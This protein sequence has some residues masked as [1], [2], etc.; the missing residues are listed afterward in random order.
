M[1]QCSTCSN[2]IGLQ[3][4]LVL[5]NSNAHSHSKNAGAKISRLEAELTRVENLIVQLSQQR[6]RLKKEI[7]ALSLTAQL[8]TEILLEIFRAVTHP[9]SINDIHQLGLCG[10]SP[11]LLGKV[12]S[13]W[14]DVAWTAPLLWA[15]IYIY[16]S[17][18]RYTVQTQLLGEWLDRADNLPLNIRLSVKAEDELDWVSDPPREVMSQLA[19]YSATWRSVDLFLPGSCYQHI[20]AIKDD[21]PLLA[22][23][24][25]HT[26]VS[27]SGKRLGMFYSAPRLRSVSL[28][29]YFLSD[30]HLPWAQF[31]HLHA[32]TFFLDE[33]IEALRRA[34]DLV[35]C[36]FRSIIS[37]FSC[38]RFQFPT[39]PIV[40][41]NLIN[42]QLFSS[43]ST[44]IHD[45]LESVTLTSLLQLELDISYGQLFSSDEHVF[46]LFLLRSSPPLQRLSIAGSPILENALLRCLHAIPSLEEL[47]LT[48]PCDNPVFGL[49][50]TFI[51]ALEIN[52]S[53]G[54]FL[55]IVP[56][57]QSFTYEGPASFHA[58]LLL[59][60]LEKRC[61]KGTEGL[62]HDTK[63][64]KVSIQ[65]GSHIDGLLK[66]PVRLMRLKA[67]GVRLSF[68]TGGVVWC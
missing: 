23:L 61:L 20:E 43:E 44:S 3:S 48:A 39:E 40:L 42:F 21:L 16:L 66:V 53:S 17:R 22:S 34:P 38:S 26:L 30:I 8:P 9:T 6:S 56:K 35:R 2:T 15:D 14:R 64:T 5:T 67:E 51:S 4:S 31:A 57:L 65:T 13:A 32:E 24:S 19:T 36:Q 29:G 1:T 41:D 47:Q 18:D 27:S 33:C 12:C 46:E 28:A 59:D 49:S 50:N 55:D 60:M 25:L 63:L 45:L 10:V 52:Q 68:A 54:E 7:N 58:S 11:L 62:Y 37:G